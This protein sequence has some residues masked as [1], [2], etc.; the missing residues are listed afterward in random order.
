MASAREGEIL[1]HVSGGVTVVGISIGGQSVE[2]FCDC[3]SC[4]ES[5]FVDEL[6]D[7]EV[8]MGTGDW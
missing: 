4:G 1:L 8:L 5:S 2:D 7:D 3:S 6:F